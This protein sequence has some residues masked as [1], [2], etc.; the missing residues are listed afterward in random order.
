[1]N[2]RPLGYEGDFGDERDRL[3]STNTRS[4]N[5]L[6]SSRFGVTRAGLGWVLGQN[7]DSPSGR[8]RRPDLDPEQAMSEYVLLTPEGLP[9]AES[10]IKRHFKPAKAIA[11]ITRRFHD[12]RHTFARKGIN[13]FTLRD[14]LGACLDQDDRTLRAAKHRGFAA[15]AALHARAMRDQAHGPC[16]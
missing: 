16:S 10:T 8:D 6:R 12:Q 5:G 15:V 9:Y 4:F 1:M 3:I 13:S 14:L 7:S 11:D 2:L